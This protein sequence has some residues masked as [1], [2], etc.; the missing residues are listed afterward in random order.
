MHID[1]SLVRADVSWES[2]VKR[3]VDEVMTENRGEEEVEGEKRQRRSARQ[4]QEGEP[5]RCGR[6]HGDLGDA[7]GDLSRATSSTRRWTT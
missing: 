6:E 2:L 1:A 7:T 5:H 3:H 4:V